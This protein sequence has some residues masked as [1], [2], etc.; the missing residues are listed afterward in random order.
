[1]GAYDTGAYDK[2]RTGPLLGELRGIVV[3]E[4]AARGR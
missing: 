1:M 2:E 4:S 3:V